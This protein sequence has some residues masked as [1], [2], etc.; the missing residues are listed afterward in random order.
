MKEEKNLL[1]LKLLNAGHMVPLDLP[2]QSLEMMQTFMSGESFDQSPQSINSQDKQDSCPACP[3]STCDVCDDCSLVSKDDDSNN[4]N[5]STAPSYYQK[6]SN[7]TTI[8]WVITGLTM[9]ALIVVLIRSRKQPPLHQELVS[10]YDLELRE[11]N[12]SDQQESK[13]DRGII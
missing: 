13:A 4:S 8:S 9:V 12:Y 5:S 1:F 2:K 3:S 7:A 11:V 6:A 10:Q